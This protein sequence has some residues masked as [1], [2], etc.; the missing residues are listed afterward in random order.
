MTLRQELAAIVS[1]RSD[2][3]S[4]EYVCWT[5]ID[6]F[7]QFNLSGARYGMCVQKDLTDIVGRTGR[8]LTPD[9]VARLVIRRLHDRGLLDV[10]DGWLDD[11]P[12]MLEDLAE[13][14]DIPA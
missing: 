6:C 14:C 12:Q 8:G 13:T 5:I 3:T 10:R 9:Q 4:A 2:G 7:S 1:R 11:D